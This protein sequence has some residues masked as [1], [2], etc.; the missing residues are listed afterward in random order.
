MVAI[1]LENPKYPR[2]VGN[3]VRACSCYGIPELVFT[4]SRVS[5]EP[6]P[7]YRLPRE[8]RMR[9]YKDVQVSVNDRPLDKFD[10]ATMVGVELLHGATPL[11]YYEHPEDAVY[12]FGPE[13]GGITKGMR[14]AI[15]H[16]VFIPTRHCTNLSAAVYTVL[17]D[18]QLKQHLNG[19]MPVMSVEDTLACEPVA[20]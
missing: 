19:T 18:R 5:L 7:G 14:S 12:V 15:H 4:G 20:L 9:G 3:A 10:G 6:Y 8:E 1:I 11:T 2:N 17:Y 13:D 16:F